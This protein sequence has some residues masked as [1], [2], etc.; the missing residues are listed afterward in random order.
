[1]CC[2][3]E[4]DDKGSISKRW[5]PSHVSSPSS[6]AFVRRPEQR[7]NSHGDLVVKPVR[8]DDIAN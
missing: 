4:D 7:Q 1:M 3:F 5:S 6:L 8:G 2:S